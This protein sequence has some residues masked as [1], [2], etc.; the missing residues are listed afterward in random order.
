MT[1]TLAIHL[2]PS[3][4]HAAIDKNGRID[5][6][7]LGGDQAGMPMVLHVDAEGAVVAG[8][9]AL[10][11]GAKDPQG[12]LEDPIGVLADSQTVEIAGRT[13]TGEV[14]L[15]HLLTQ[16][17]AQSIQ[18]LDGAPDETLVVLTAG[19]P[20][21]S[22]YAAAT[23]RA[24]MGKVEFVNETRAWSAMA[25]H[26]PSNADSELSGVL[27]GLFWKRHGDA[28]AAPKGRVTREDLGHEA[29]T[30]TRVPQPPPSVI[31][32]G[33][34]SVFEEAAPV[35]LR[36]KRRSPWVILALLAVIGLG[37]VAALAATGGQE[38]APMVITPAT[39][40]S[41]T[42]STTTTL[43]STTTFTP[44][45]E[46]TTSTSTTTSTTTT[47][48][49]TTTTTTTLPPLGQVTMTPVGLLLDALESDRNMVAFGNPVD[50]VLLTFQE[51]FGAP[52]SDTGWQEN[53]TC[54]AP[55]VRTVTYGDKEIVFADQDIDDGEPGIGATFEQWYISGPWAVESSI[56]TLSRIGIGSTVADIRMAYPGNFSIGLAI[57]GDLS[58]FFTF[59]STGS[60]DGVYGLS[61][62]TEDTGIVL[63]MWAGNVCSRIL[64]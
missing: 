5:L 15:A 48:A 47:L 27:G 3:L 10:E 49:P 36:R 6:I 17:H 9:S 42:T 38:K 33:S 16:V 56:W 58:G 26:G 37:V 23:Q 24:L 22:I 7:A 29:P 8:R 25:T 4:A 52:D 39:S 28:P 63:D 19:G 62:T 53:A 60:D 14:L 51:A 45:E 30:T 41:T 35:S 43:A 20:D 57:D 50:D 54:F 32:V 34:R 2:G 21:Q 46:T 64:S 59:D 31:S 11:R 1:T 55:M 40:T 44:V 12:L 13:M 61:N 18:V